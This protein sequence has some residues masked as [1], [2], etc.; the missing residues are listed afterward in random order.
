M[1]KENDIEFIVP[2]RAEPR[3]GA[4]QIDVMSLRDFE[5][6]VNFNQAFLDATRA[7]MQAGKTVEEAASSL[8]LPDA[9]RSYGMSRAKANI[10][11]IYDEL[12]R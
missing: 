10:Q 5:E 4:M 6:Y 12:T 11:A 9:Y 1:F 8:I 3:R 7:A 2:G